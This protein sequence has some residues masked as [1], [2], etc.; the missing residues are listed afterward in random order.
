[1]YE[2]YR[3][4]LEPIGECI[5]SAGLCG[6]HVVDPGEECEVHTILGDDWGRIEGCWDFGTFQP[7]LGEL[8]CHAPGTEHECFFDTRTCEALV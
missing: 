6:N 1:M 5:K 2:N 7:G 3:T 4:G 8:K